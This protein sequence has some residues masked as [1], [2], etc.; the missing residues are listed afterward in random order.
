[1]TCP[2]DTFDLSPATAFDSESA[3]PPLSCPPSTHRLKILDC[4]FVEEE[5]EH[6]E[7]VVKGGIHGFFGGLAVS[8]PI[9]YVMSKRNH[10]YRTLPIPLKA[11]GWV[12][13][14]SLSDCLLTW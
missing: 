5:D 11:F 3:S 7:Q 6:Q 9:F 12:V 1:L 10:W 4:E 14:R 13:V 2:T 8:T